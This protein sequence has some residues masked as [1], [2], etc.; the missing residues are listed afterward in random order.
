MKVTAERVPDSQVELNVEVEP[1]AVAKAMDKAYRRL[2]GRMNVPGFRR[3]KAPRYIVE[4]LVGR[5]TLW[6]EGLEELIPGVYR[7][8]VREADIRPIAD[9]Q[10][11]VVQQEPLVL[12]FVVPVQPN[13]ELGDYHSI[14][15]PKVE[16]GVTDEDVAAAL[17]QLREQ[18]AEWVPVQ[19]AA[20]VGDQVKADVQGWVGAVPLLYS[21]TGET[22]VKS[23][24]AETIIDS[25]D[26]KIWVSPENRFPV[27]GFAEQLVGFQ[28]GQ[29]KEFRITLP[30]DFRPEEYANR[31]AAFKVTVH[32]VEEERLPTLDD[33][34]AKKVGD[35]ESFDALR[36]DLR[37]QLQYKVETEARRQLEDLV[38]R[39]VVDQSTVELPPSIV[40]REVDRLI[41]RLRDRLKSQNMSMDQ[42]LKIVDKTEDQ[43]RDDL[44]DDAIRNLKTALVLD[45]VA[46]I[47]HIEVSTE[48]VA[49]RIDKLAE[50]FGDKAKEAAEAL[51]AP[52]SR[53]NIAFNLR[54]QRTVDRLVELAT[55]EETAEG[56]SGAESAS[57]V[58]ESEP[59]PGE[60]ERAEPESGHGSPEQQ[61]DQQGLE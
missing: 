4:R 46:D 33:E 54:T 31:S 2:V 15:V 48:E 49:E 14:R 18:H 56:L 23:A 13:V 50:A 30:A 6:Q 27:P 3:G 24:E 26:I 51:G 25:K 16:V 34:F 39:M 57:G 59:A 19:R 45:K 17:E 35:Y 42:Y 52:E 37:Q 10:I 38:V 12:K 41:D 53:G 29:T 40:D 28:A 36:E 55:S 8:A 20:E 43:V 32:E 58:E 7:E 21:T 1:E 44:R 60:A 61:D 11:D 5:E 47:E 9:P 22:L